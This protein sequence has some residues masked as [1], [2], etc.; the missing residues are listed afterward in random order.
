MSK[1]LQMLLEDEE[2]GALCAIE[3]AKQLSVRSEEF[4]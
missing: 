1:R 4:E 2:V 3:N